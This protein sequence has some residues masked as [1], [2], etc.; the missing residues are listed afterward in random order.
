MDDS[1]KNYLYSELTDKI[2]ASAYKVHN[3]LGAGFLEKV[4]E[5]AMIIELKK[6]DLEVFQQ[7]PVSVYYDGNIIGEYFADLLVEDKVILELKAINGLTAVHEIQLQNYL[8]A[9]GIKVG[10]LI[11]FGDKI[12]IKRKVMQTKYEPKNINNQHKS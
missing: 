9:T 5:N 7:H 2:I 12:T 11:N 3:K 10:L 8:K 6:I 4:Y 1:Y